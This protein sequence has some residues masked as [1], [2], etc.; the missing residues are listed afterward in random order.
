V[1]TEELVT[2]MHEIAAESSGPITGNGPPG[3]LEAGSM[4][5]TSDPQTGDVHLLFT[6]GVK[7]IYDPRN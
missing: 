6:N 5:M 1:Q 7:L 2:S 4:T 3:Q